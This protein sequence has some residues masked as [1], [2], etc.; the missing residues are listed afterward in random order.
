MRAKI[1]ETLAAL[2]KET[3]PG[4]VI[5]EFDREESGFHDI[6]AKLERAL[7]KIRGATLEWQTESDEPIYWDHDFDDDFDPPPRSIGRS[8][9]GPARARRPG[10]TQG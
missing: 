8:G 9:A 6:H 4:G 10:A 7:R 3:W 2:I 5:G 1:P